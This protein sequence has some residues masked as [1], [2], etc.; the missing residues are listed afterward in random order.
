VSVYPY[1]VLRAVARDRRFWRF[2][3]FLAL[4]AATGAIALLRAHREF[5]WTP[6]A[7]RDGVR[8]WGTLAPLAFMAAWILRPFIFFPSTLLFVAGGLAFG[9]GWGTLYAA[10]GGTLGAVVGFSISRLLGREFVQAQLGDRLP[11]VQHARWGVGL[12]FLMN[13]VPVVPMTV[14]NYGAGLSNMELLPFAAAAVAGLTPR[15][16]AYSLFGNSL[17]NV[18][19]HEF[20][21]ALGLLG[22][23]LVVPLYVRRHLAKHRAVLPGQG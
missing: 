12:V 18:Q 11:D 21:I 7:I 16:F 1:R 14:I 6:D 20:L 23:L 3:F 19:S 8:S 17:L 4:L 10:C 22:A 9:I 2:I 13:L 15:A 5:L